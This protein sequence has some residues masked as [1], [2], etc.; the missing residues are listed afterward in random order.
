MT[1]DYSRIINDVVIPN[2]KKFGFTLSLYRNESITTW[3][4]GFDPVASRDYWESETTGEIVYTEPTETLVEY[5]VTALESNFTNRE[6]AGK[7]ILRGDKR[8]YIVPGVIEPQ[9]GD[10]V[11]DVV[12][13]RIYDVNIIKPADVIILYEVYARV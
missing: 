12:K 5:P 10:V 13:Y 11:E 2:I 6:L 9:K 4:K 8:Y 1:F 7:D 3:T